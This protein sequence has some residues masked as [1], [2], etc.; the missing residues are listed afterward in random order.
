M[1]NGHAEVE[2]RS[3]REISSHLLGQE[4]L[5][6]F[7]VR[8]THLAT[9][10]GNGKRFGHAPSVLGA[11]HQD[12][13]GPSRAQRRGSS[14]REFDLRGRYFGQRQTQRALL[15]EDE[16]IRNLNR[17][18]IGLECLQFY[19]EVSALGSLERACEC[20]NPVIGSPI[21]AHA[22]SHAAVGLQ[23]PRDFGAVGHEW[24]EQQVLCVSALAIDG[25]EQ[26]FEPQS[27]HTGANT[28]CLVHHN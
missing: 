6:V 27:S 24:R 8:V 20:N 23:P 28:M 16:S 4:S 3:Q 15:R 11:A 13:Y 5:D 26:Q 10:L 25:G 12:D 14:C 22:D 2:Q 21:Q 19:L 1:M 18:L 9:V 7:D 17:I